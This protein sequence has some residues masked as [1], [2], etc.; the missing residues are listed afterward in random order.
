[1]RRL[2]AFIL[3]FL[4]FSVLAYDPV[5]NITA[6]VPEPSAEALHIKTNGNYFA[7]FCAQSPFRL[8][9]Y[10]RGGATSILTLPTPTNN[11]VRF[12]LTGDFDF[13]SSNRLCGLFMGSGSGTPQLT[14]WQLGTELPFPTTAT[15]ITN[16]SFTPLTN[17]DFPWVVR[18][19]NG[20]IVAG[21]SED[22]LCNDTVGL[23]YRYPNGTWTNY[24]LQTLFYPIP[25]CHP[26]FSKAV[27]Q[28][29]DGSVFVFT[30]KDSNQAIAASQY[31]VQNGLTLITNG[32]HSWQADATNCP[33][34]EIPSFDGFSDY[35][36]NRIMTTFNT[37]H[38]YFS[39]SGDTFSD[40]VTD[41]E[42][43]GLRTNLTWA[44]FTDPGNQGQWNYYDHS[45]LFLSTAQ[46]NRVYRLR[47]SPVSC[48]YGGRGVSGA[49][50]FTLKWIQFNTN[51][52][53]LATMLA[54]NVSPILRETF[55]NGVPGAISLI[56]YTWQTAQGTAYFPYTGDYMYVD[57]NNV[58]HL[59]IDPAGAYYVDPVAGNDSNDG[60]SIATAWKHLPGSQNGT[61]TNVLFAGDTVVVKGGTTN[62]SRV[63]INPTNYVGS[64]V[65]NSIL[66]QSGDLYSPAWGTGRA[67]IDGGGTNTAG[68]GLS[69]TLAAGPLNGITIDGFEVRNISAGAAGPGYDNSTGS[70]C[71]LAGSANYPA[72][73]L[74]IKRCYLHDAARSIDNEGHG[75]EFAGFA[76]NFLVYQ[77][78]IGPRIGT[79][80]IE[81]VHASFG[82]ISNNFISGTG[83]HCISLNGST[84]I[85]VA[86]NT[87]AN[88]PPWVHEPQYALSMAD[89]RQCDVWNNLF[90]RSVFP[91]TNSVTERGGMGVGIYGISISNRLVFNTVAYFNDPANGGSSESGVSLQKLATNSWTELY[92]NLIISNQSSIGFIGFC[93]DTASTLSN[94]MSFCDVF[95]NNSSENVMATETANVD[96]LFTVAGFNPSIGVYAN[97]QQL[98]PSFLGGPL[99]SGIDAN[100]FPNT[101]YFIMGH[102][103][104]VS[105]WNTGNTNSGDAVHGYSHAANKFQVSDIRGVPRN[106]WSMGA[107]EFDQGSIVPYTNVS[108]FMSG[109]TFISGKVYIK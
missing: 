48:L 24:G 93:A 71:I 42:V 46:T 21:A 101:G 25:T 30:W 7:I 109:K 31:S 55:I 91:V 60:R 51:Y 39:P 94:R 19:S 70:S 69:G 43:T 107:Y 88:N 52:I 18:M 16:F 82:V 57:T 29:Q 87:V 75:I 80:G 26:W 2:L 20:S 105:V 33:Y 96:T 65:F 47:E 9:M 17:G 97:N 102:G 89:A 1:M 86:N 13:A 66:V 73:W 45:V 59:I 92:N 53:D 95:A 35:A 34:G 77:N 44:P 72:N 100:Y 64:N 98:D 67:I 68:F 78:V 6:G 83:D 61:V 38:Y 5:L 76:T 41:V 12:T 74:T 56:D 90:Y 99:P 8:F 103:A 36:S 27:E 79:K 15:V 104:P 63:E 106:T 11:I 108:V 32:M 85:D 54:T 22:H 4:C 84:N 23:L 40:R 62:Y 37:C 10:N 50:M 14:E 81:P 49:N 3:L 28:P 58:W